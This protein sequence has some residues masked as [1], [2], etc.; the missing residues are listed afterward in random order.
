MRRLVHITQH[1]K[2]L[3]SKVSQLVGTLQKTHSKKCTDIQSSENYS[4]WYQ[5]LHYKNPINL[6]FS[7]DQFMHELRSKYSQRTKISNY[8][9]KL[10]EQKKLSLFYGSLPRSQIKNYCSRSR[11]S[12]GNFSKNLISFLESRLDVVVY[13]SGFTKNILN[14]RQLITHKKVLVNDKILSIPSYL[15]N[16][17]DVIALDPR[18]RVQ[19][20]QV[21]LKD[22]QKYKK[23]TLD[24]SFLPITLLENSSLQQTRFTKQQV[25]LFVLL[26]AKKIFSRA[27]IKRYKNPFLHSR[28]TLKFP[29]FVMCRSYQ[30]RERKATDVASQRTFNKNEMTY[31]KKV[32]LECMKSQKRTTLEKKIFLL[33]L[34][35]YLTKQL[36]KTENIEIM[37]L[38]NKK[39]L[40]LEIS[41]KLWTSI[42]LYSPQRIYYPFLLDFDILKRA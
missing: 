15:V 25:D 17:G 19:I 21:F 33:Q 6:L 2:N 35:K 34:K 18:I 20:H 10:K 32:F 37:G 23:K 31:G 38:K 12:P 27:F 3:L 14:A 36:S 9:I 1:Q 4:N 29:Y 40:H 30:Y 41:Y 11:S 5:S 22:F 7:C 13:R 42:Y 28:N 8:K 39:P 16:P 24:P 26:L